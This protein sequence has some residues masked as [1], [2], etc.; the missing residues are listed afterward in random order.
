[1]SPPIALVLD[2]T[3]VCVVTRDGRNATH[4]IAWNPEQSDVMIDA[5]R[6]VVGTPSHIVLVVGLAHLEI[7]RPELP[8][9]TP[10][11]KRAV[12]LR[13]A[14][15]YFPIAEPIAVAILDG[16]ALATPSVRLAAWV[17]AASELGA[18]RVVVAAPTIAV[19]L[20]RHGTYTL[21]VGAHELGVL[22]V[23]SGVVQSLRRQSIPGG[24]V[25]GAAH[26]SGTNADSRNVCSSEQI[27][28]EAL[29]QL[30]L[31][32]DAQL[33][34]DGLDAMLHRARTRQFALAVVLALAAVLLLAWSADRWR[35]AVLNATEARVAVL[36]TDVQPAERALH[37]EQQA[38][39]EFALLHLS[40]KRASAPNAPLFVLASVT[41]VLPKDT[42]VQ[43]LTWD[44]SQW[45][46]EGTTDNAPRLVPLLDGDV[47][48][49]DVH[50]A[51]AGQRFLDAG[52]QRESFA[53]NF[54]MQHAEGADVKR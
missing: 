47:R 30:A 14:D 27:G 53:I 37:R 31:P 46:V 21:P 1:M 45:R 52:K 49:R 8:P 35:G 23:A 18:V 16:F 24:A 29:R 33:L 44:G 32:L 4:T 2:A 19:R 22:E 50:V 5:V 39:A 54:A 13:D 51:S 28:R 34:D 10:A 42:F 9:I 38:A 3:T 26:E 11:A 20:A 25:D 17:S 12:L 15:R 48:F 40:T 43:R 7:A 41:Q 6:A 36:E